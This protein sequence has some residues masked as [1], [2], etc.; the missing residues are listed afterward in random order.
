MTPAEAHKILDDALD[1]IGEHFDAVQIHATWMYDGNTSECVH[2][3]SGNW[4]ARE[5]MAREF[6]EQNK[7]DEIGQSVAKRIPPQ[8]PGDDGDKWK[9]ES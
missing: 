5:S 3:G 6:I 1:I 7:A 4:Y 2:R 8:S 9:S